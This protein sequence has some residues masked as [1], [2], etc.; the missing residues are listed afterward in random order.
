MSI[1]CKNSPPTGFYVYAYIRKSNLTPYYIGK[2]TGRRVTGRHHI[3]IPKDLTKIIILEQNLTEVG[4]LAIERRLI[5]WWGRKDLGTGILHNK[6]E[7]GEGNTGYNH[8]SKT[9]QQ[10]SKSTTGKS[11]EPFTKEHIKNLSLAHSGKKHKNFGIQL[12]NST[13][14]NISIGVKKTYHKILV[15]CINC[16]TVTNIGNYTKHH[17]KNCKH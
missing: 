14:Q 1:Y 11:K 3:S 6:S 15:S 5:L 2:G 10:I 16:R 13:K 8:T 17:S 7:G 4:A 9:K 12:P